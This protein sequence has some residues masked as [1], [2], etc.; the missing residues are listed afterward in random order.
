[1][2]GVAENFHTEQNRE[3]LEQ[4]AA[5]TGGRYWRPQDLSKL[6]SEISYSEAGITMRETKDL[7][8][9][10]VVFS[11]DRAAAVRRVAAAAEVG[12]GMK[13]RD[14]VVVA[15]GAAAVALPARAAIYYVTV[16]GP[17]RRAGLR[18][19]LHGAGQGSG[20]AA[21]GSRRRRARLHAVRRAT[22][23][24]RASPRCWDRSPREAKPDD[25]FVLMLIGHGTFD[26]VDYKFNLSARIIS[27]GRAGGAVRPHCRQAAA[28]REHDQRQR[29][30]A[31]AAL[32]K[33]GRARDHRDQDRHR[34]E[35]HRVRA[36]LG[37]SA[38]RSGGRR[39][40]ERSRSARSKPSIRRAQDRGVLRSR[41]S[42][43]PPS[44]PCSKTPARA[45]RVRAPSAESGE[46]R[47][48]RQLHAG[49]PRRSAEG[50]ARSGQADAARQEGRARAADR[51]AEIPEG[52]D[53]RQTTTSS[54]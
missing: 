17:G 49:A 28:G 33:P 51:Q 38:A 26:G 50:R 32:Q 13:A 10:P 47:A 18:A 46:G 30:L 41:R 2:D 16:G 19:A 40:Q 52:G 21:Q 36:L 48:A 27:G 3:L 37:G 35:R 44:T 12:G 34:K 25:D 39:R 9:M 23:R 8:D 6:P 15:V 5:Q 1:M 4:L 24:A 11:A 53:G 45:K 43:W 22:R 7:W 31:C 29:R 20:Q 14:A 42:A 54:S